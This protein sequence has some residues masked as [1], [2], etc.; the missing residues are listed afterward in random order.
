MHRIIIV[1]HDKD[2]LELL[3]GILNTDYEVETLCSGE[4]LILRLNREEPPDLI[5]LS[6]SLPEQEGIEVL[7]K[8]HGPGAVRPIPVIMLT[9]GTEGRPE[10]ECIRA[11][12]QDYI[13][14]PFFPELVRSR[15]DSQIQLGI[16]KE[17]LRRARQE[18]LR[19]PLTGMYNRAYAESHIREYLQDC[20]GGAYFM[21]DLDNFKHVND[22]YGHTAGDKALQYVAGILTDTVGSHGI[23]CRMGGD[24]F[25]LFLHSE[26]D[27]GRIAKIA[28]NILNEYN[29]IAVEND[30]MAGTSL[31]IGI[32]IVGKDGNSCQ[33]LYNAA[34]K[35]LYFS[36]R[37]GK[38]SY[39]FYSKGVTQED[40]C[41][42]SVV[43]IQQL[44]RLI[45]DR[46]KFAG[47]YQV[48]YNEFHR[49]Y[50]FIER[51][52]ERTH[53]KAQLMLVSLWER[54]G[55]N[56]SLKLLEEE[57]QNLEDAVVRSLRRNDVSTRYSNRQILVVLIDID[58]KNVGIVRSRICDHYHETKKTDCYMVRFEEMP[59]EATAE[60]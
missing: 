40:D 43:D 55:E 59:I 38:N 14:K 22:A 49:I 9:E 58:E 15:V 19:D 31:S 29:R 12:A 21:M 16:L 11:G 24:E 52:V 6:H 18:A 13:S 23:V 7:R 26:S 48:D 60:T 51:C 34:D 44:E 25:S 20:K 8:L 54:D 27:R 17:E 53:Q 45:Q 35:A 41:H 28:V 57:V 30:S 42:D 4:D 56:G 3:S 33:E 39:Y 5:L 10:V 46:K 32:A 1:D 47:A 2:T 50:N 36:K 37:N